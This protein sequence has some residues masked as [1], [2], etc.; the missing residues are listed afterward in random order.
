MPDASAIA[1]IAAARAANASSAAQ[2]ASQE[3]SMVYYEK[4]RKELRDM[5]QRKRLLDKNL[6]QYEENIFKAEAAYLEETQN[7]NIIKGFDNYIKGTAA[8]RR[9]NISDA[10]RLFSLSSLTYAAKLQQQEDA[11]PA[12]STSTPTIPEN[13]PRLGAQSKNNKKKR[14]KG[15]DESESPSEV[16]TPGPKRVRI[17]FSGQPPTA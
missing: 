16:E 6:A 12:T 1:A 4:L 2:G 17:S 9:N 3:K 7:G 13:L 8:R 15:E 5:I 14:R 11:T 10:D